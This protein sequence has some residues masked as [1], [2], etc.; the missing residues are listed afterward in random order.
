MVQAMG[1]L[2]YEK[3]FLTNLVN[4]NLLRCHYDISLFMEYA[5][6]CK[7]FEKDLLLW[8]IFHF[9]KDCLH[10]FPWKHKLGLIMSSFLLAG[11]Q[12]I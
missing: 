2:P 9:P 6:R 3:V 4:F 7:H 8:K 10:T 1:H 11:W 5:N 12:G